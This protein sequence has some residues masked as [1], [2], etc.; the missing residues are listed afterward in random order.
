MLEKQSLLSSVQLPSFIQN[1][2]G[3]GARPALQEAIL[4]LWA[5]S[6]KQGNEAS[7]NNS[8]PVEILFV[9]KPKEIAYS[10]MFAV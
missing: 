10:I 2:I 7:N 3:R 6:A 1:Q 8:D 4:D 5:Y 9:C